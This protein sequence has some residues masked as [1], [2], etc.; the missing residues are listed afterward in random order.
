M[1][2]RRG[3][4]KRGNKR[5]RKRRCFISIDDSGVEGEEEEEFV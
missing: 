4:R 3:R 5:R 2:G 1:E